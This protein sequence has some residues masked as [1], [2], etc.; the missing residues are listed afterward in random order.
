[1]SRSSGGHMDKSCFLPWSGGLPTDPVP[2]VGPVLHWSFGV[3]L[4]P[5]FPVEPTDI[6]LTALSG[7]GELKE[8][9]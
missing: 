1:M 2:G 5:E 7:E 9:G 4:F 3:S 6:S 8:L